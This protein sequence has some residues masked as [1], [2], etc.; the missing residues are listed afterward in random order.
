MDRIP[1]FKPVRM[2]GT[3]PP[4]GD[5]NMT[6]VLQGKRIFR[7]LGQISRKPSKPLINK[8]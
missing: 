3:L 2:R 8:N 1:R 6:F 5:M 4:A 7:A